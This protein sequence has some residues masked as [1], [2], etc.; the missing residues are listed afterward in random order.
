M[1]H[2][3][4]PTKLYLNQK[5]VSQISTLSRSTLERLERT[6]PPSMPVPRRFGARC[7]RYLTADIQAWLDGTWTPGGHEVSHV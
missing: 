5:E 3:N 2:T 7:K 1:P 6:N 4:I